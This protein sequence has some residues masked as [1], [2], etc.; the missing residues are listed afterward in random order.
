MGHDC[1]A[2]GHLALGQGIEVAAPVLVH[3]A[4]AEAFD[5]DCEIRRDYRE[6]AIV[7]AGGHGVIARGMMGTVAMRV[8]LRDE[9]LVPRPER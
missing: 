9:F 4:L 6:E 8:E 1:E 5:A 7:E 2:A 3:D